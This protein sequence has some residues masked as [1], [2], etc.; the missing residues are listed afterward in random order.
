MDRISIFL[1]IGTF[2]FETIVPALHSY[3]LQKFN[4]DRSKFITSSNE[5]L[6]LALINTYE[7]LKQHLMKKEKQ[8]SFY[9]RY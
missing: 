3:L 9:K 4:V 6:K 2:R 7:F 1:L 5:F 8:H